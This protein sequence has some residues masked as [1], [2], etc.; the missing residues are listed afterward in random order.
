[1]ALI[2]GI[3][4]CSTCGVVLESGENWHPSMAGQNAYLCKTC[5]N[6]RQR[7]YRNNSNGLSK[8]FTTDLLNLID[9]LNQFSD[10]YGTVNIEVINGIEAWRNNLKNGGNPPITD[11]PKMMGIKTQ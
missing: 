6:E 1:M 8:T 11:L 7:R 2:D 9:Q 10:K 3:P 4:Y 5:H